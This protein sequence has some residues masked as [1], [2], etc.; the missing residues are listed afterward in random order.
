MIDAVNI[1]E[2]KTRFSKLIK[3]V[4][5]GEEIVIARAGTPIARLVPFR[6][7]GARKPGSAKGLITM[8]PDFDA[9]LPEDLQNPEDFIFEQGAQNGFEILPIH[10]AHALKTYSLSH[11]HGDPFDRS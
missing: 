6:E 11:H 2:A 1:H 10:L 9:P 3:R 8:G 4:Q 7:K 5:M